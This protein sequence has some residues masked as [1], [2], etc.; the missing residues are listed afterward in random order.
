MISRTARESTNSTTVMSM[1]AIMFRANVLVKAF[2][3]R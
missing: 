2:S 3:V 1:K